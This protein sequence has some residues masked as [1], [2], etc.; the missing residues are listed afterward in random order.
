MTIVDFFAADLHIALNTIGYLVR[1]LRDL[2]LSPDW[3]WKLSSQNLFQTSSQYYPA[4]KTT[5]LTT[6][7]PMSQVYGE[8]NLKAIDKQ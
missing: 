8:E 1:V 5:I 6:V 7:N 3:G 4:P 2:N